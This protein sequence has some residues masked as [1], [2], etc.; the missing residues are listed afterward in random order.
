M[1][2]SLISKSFKRGLNSQDYIVFLIL[3]H[4]RIT[5]LTLKKLTKIS[6]TYEWLNVLFLKFD[7]KWSKTMV[8][9]YYTFWNLRIN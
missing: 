8:H 3:H 4:K 7:K 5:L 9:F 6:E 1:K 2:G